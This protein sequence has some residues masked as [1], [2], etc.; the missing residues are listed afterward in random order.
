MEILWKK[1][2]AKGTY[3]LYFDSFDKLMDKVATTGL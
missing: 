2:K 1:I 3:L